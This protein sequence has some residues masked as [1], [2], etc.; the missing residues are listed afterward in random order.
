MKISEASWSAAADVFRH[1]DLVDLA[2]YDKQSNGR[3]LAVESI[4]LTTA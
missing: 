2:M 1:Y 3:R 4:V